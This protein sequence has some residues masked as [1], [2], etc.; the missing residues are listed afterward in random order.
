MT[1]RRPN[2]GVR[3]QI[4]VLENRVV[5]T[6]FAI[7]SLALGSAD[8]YLHQIN[9]RTSGAAFQTGSLLTVDLRNKVGQPGLD[10]LSIIDDGKGN[11]QVSWDG[12]PVHSFKGINQIVF[13]SAQTQT[14]QVAF[15]LTGPL[16]TSLDVQLNLNGKDNVVTEQ[17]G[18]NGVVP[19]GLTF[20]IVAV[21]HN[22]TIQTI[23]TP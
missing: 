20:E 22:S 6:G 14:E 3:L 1:Q 10:T 5:P 19:N 18:N 16:V 4:E 9:P 2:V 8:Q 21:R 17:V 23:I 15:K 11:I 12:G 13:N 7:S